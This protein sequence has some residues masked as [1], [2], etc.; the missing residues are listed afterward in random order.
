MIVQQDYL[1]DPRVRREAEA[2]AEAGFSVDVISL[3]SKEQPSDQVVNS[4]HIYGVRLD[5]KY[6][7]IGRYLFEYFVF[8]VCASVLAMRLH[9]R[10]RYD[11]VQV[12]NLPDTLVFAALLPKVTRACVLF[13]AHESMP[14]SFRMRFGWSEHDRRYKIVLTVQ[15]VCMSLADHVITIHEPMRQLFIR[16]GIAANK[17]SVVMN[18]PDEKRFKAARE[19]EIEPRR[20]FTLI[21]TGTIARRYGLQTVLR[22]LPFLISRIPGTRLRIIGRGD[23]V[24]VLRNLAGDLGISGHVSFESWIP[25]AEIASVYRSADVGISP[26]EDPVF[27]DIYFSTKVAEFLATGLPAIV[28]RTPVMQ[29]YYSCSEVAFFTPGDHVSL[30][31]LVYKVYRNPA[32]RN[33]LVEN[34]LK[35]SQRYNWRNEQDSYI[36]L[37]KRLATGRRSGSRDVLSTGT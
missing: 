9:L 27:G 11:I 14:E 3:C 5:R 26:Q 21:Y 2:L 18:W 30:A 4:V 13:D 36:K 8:L 24:P 35:L 19:N 22:A 10:R 15:Q 12:A 28:A 17:I 34:G 33:S 1:I 32:Y 29:H 7:T 16:R 37:M 20:G 23:Y 6:G 31:E 25:L